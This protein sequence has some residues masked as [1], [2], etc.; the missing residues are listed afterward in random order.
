MYTLSLEIINECNL[1]CKY[2]YLGEKKNKKMTEDTAKSA[3][4]I[5]IHEAKKQNDKSLIVYFIGGEPVLAFDLLKFCVEYTIKKCHENGLTPSFS[6]T[7]N[8][9]LLDRDKINF[10]IKHTFDLKIS[11]DGIE[12]SHDLNRK[13][14]NNQGSYKD[15]LSKL[16]L[17]W[18]Y[19]K[20]T[21]KI[22]HAANV[23]TPNNCNLFYDNIR[24]LTDIGFRIVES[25]VDIYSEWSEE[26]FDVIC[27]QMEEAFANY[28]GRKSKGEKISWK[29][30]EDR[31]EN[32]YTSV[33]FFG[34]KA[35]L[36][37]IYVTAEGNI[38][39]CTEIDE[40]VMIGNVFEGLDV[41]RIRSFVRCNHSE[42]DECINCPEVSHCKACGC[43]MNNYELNKDFY[44][45]I[46]IS[47]KMTKFI[48]QLLR[49][50]LSSSQQAAF[51]KFY[52]KRSAMNA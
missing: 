45:P 37:S 23:I 27:K 13:Y 5:A 22:C 26:N 20:A 34:C 11:I 16:P 29:Y 24:H 43:I 18:E 33:V 36:I 28:C 6:T 38:Y 2:C 12:D 7:T 8:G 14:Y 35:G 41:G 19:E 31:I 21:G 4:D 10:L 9:T 49:S 47:C 51:E 52:Q 17:I 50:K 1:N 15:I 40:N 25:A 32:L 46:E 39:P 48:F 30:F 44:K 3:M 42:N